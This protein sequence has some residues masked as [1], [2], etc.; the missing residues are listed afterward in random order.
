VELT[1]ETVF[2][3]DEAFERKRVTLAARLAAAE[4]N[5][6]VITTHAVPGAAVQLRIIATV[7]VA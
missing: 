7:R 5:R 4:D 3:A 6:V 1:V 2:A